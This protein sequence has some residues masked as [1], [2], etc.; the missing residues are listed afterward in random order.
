MGACHYGGIILYNGLYAHYG[1]IILFYGGLM[2]ILPLYQYILA[3]P[4]APQGSRLPATSKSCGEPKTAP[5]PQKG[6]N[7]G[8]LRTL[9]D[10]FF[11]KHLDMKNTV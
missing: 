4:S 5:S 7:F 1:G 11:L 10:N 6:K 3:V 9:T 8:H 2:I